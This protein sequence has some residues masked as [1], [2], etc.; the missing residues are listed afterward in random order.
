MSSARV[1]RPADPSG[2]RPARAC[3][4]GSTLSPLT[5]RAK[6]FLLGGFS[7]ARPARRFPHL[8]PAGG[9][10]RYAR[11]YGA[12][13][14]GGSAFPDCR[15][16]LRI[17][18]RIFSWRCEPPSRRTRRARRAGWIFEKC[19]SLGEWVEWHNMGV[20]VGDWAVPLGI[21]YVEVLMCLKSK[22]WEEVM[23]RCIEISQMPL[24]LLK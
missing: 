13:S 14:A 19:C 8:P 6:G 23:G 15:R 21:K 9:L 11:L 16:A 1:R 18:P 24:E 10:F 7:R 4:E 3:A 17:F 12:T 22:L 2:S 5:S 20:S